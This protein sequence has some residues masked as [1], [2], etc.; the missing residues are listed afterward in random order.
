MTGMRRSN[1]NSTAIK[2]IRKYI[3]GID[4]YI[5]QQYTSVITINT[6]C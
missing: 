1:I 5:R 4:I 6:S 3:E 2:K